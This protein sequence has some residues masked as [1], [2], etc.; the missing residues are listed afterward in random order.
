MTAS[1][2]TAELGWTLFGTAVLAAVLAAAAG[3]AVVAG[4]ETPRTN[5]AVAFA[6]TICLAGGVGAGSLPGGQPPIRPPGWQRAW[7]P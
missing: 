1:K 2:R 6:A 5:E 7:E 4:G 3:L